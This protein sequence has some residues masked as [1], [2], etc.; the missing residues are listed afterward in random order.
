MALIRI[1]NKSAYSC[2]NQSCGAEDCRSCFP[3]ISAIKCD[4]CGKIADPMN[5]DFPNNKY[6][7]D[8]NPPKVEE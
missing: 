7:Q 1:S 8:C 6:C 5:N 4:N 2:G 3:H